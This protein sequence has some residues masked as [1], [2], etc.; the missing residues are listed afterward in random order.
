MKK[1]VSIV[2]VSIELRERQKGELETKIEFNKGHLEFLLRRIEEEVADIRN[3][4]KMGYKGNLEHSLNVI[5]CNAEAYATT[6]QELTEKVSELAKVN[7]ILE[8]LYSRRGE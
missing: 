4:E 3:N 2:E 5:K 8:S 7:E 1:Q 6:K